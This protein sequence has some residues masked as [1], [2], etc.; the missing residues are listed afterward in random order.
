MSTSTTSIDM[1]LW[2]FDVLVSVVPLGASTVTFVAIP[3]SV[4]GALTTT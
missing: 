1:I 3:P 4:K 2:L